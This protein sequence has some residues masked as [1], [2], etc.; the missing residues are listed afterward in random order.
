MLQNM[1]PPINKVMSNLSISFVCLL[2]SS[3]CLCLALTPCPSLSLCSLLS[4]SLLST[5]CSH[6]SGHI[7][8]THNLETPIHGCF[9]DNIMAAGLFFH[10]CWLL[11]LISECFLFTF[12]YTDQKDQSRKRVNNFTLTFKIIHWLISQSEGHQFYCTSSSDIYFP[13]FEYV[14]T[15]TEATVAR[16]ENHF[17]YESIAVIWV[18]N[19]SC[20]ALYKQYKTAHRDVAVAL[21]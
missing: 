13:W 15:V 2:V 20:N 1:W 9:N 17:H 7:Q 21:L 10:I 6:R 16:G 8:C 14:L 4:T 19:I 12:V 18:C 11:W 5:L 3:L